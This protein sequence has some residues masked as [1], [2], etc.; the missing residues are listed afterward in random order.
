MKKI[1]LC[2]DADPGQHNIFSAALLKNEQDYFLQ[3]AIS[4]EEAL[5]FLRESI[6][7][8]IFIDTGSDRINA[9]SVFEKLKDNSL[10]RHTKIILYG[11]VADY[12]IAEKA[13]VAG[14]TYIRKPYL[15]NT[16][17]QVLKKLI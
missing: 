10:L 1:I 5:K 3:Q 9:M 7:D 11:H 13:K 14:A 2:L 15:I 8:F 16:L 12:A 4:E 6:P 17:A